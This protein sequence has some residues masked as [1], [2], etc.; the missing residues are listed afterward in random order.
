MKIFKLFLYVL[1]L[2]CY[3]YSLPLLAQRQ[4]GTHEHWLKQVEQNPK[5]LKARHQ[6]KEQIQQYIAHHADQQE[7]QVVTI[8]VVVHV[9][10][11]VTAENISDAQIQ[12]QIDVLNED[13]SK[14]NADISNIPTA[15]AG[16]AANSQIQFCL[17][18]QTPN[19]QATN[20]IERVQTTATGFTDNNAV[21]FLDLN[22]AGQNEGG[23]P[24]WDPTRYFNLWVCKLNSGLLGY[25]QFPDNPDL[26]TYGV[27]I[28][29][30]YFGRNG[31]AESPYDLGRTATHEVGHAL[32][33]YHIWGDDGGSCFGSDNINDTPNQ[34]DA[35][36]GC[37]NFP[38]T[39]F[40]TS[41]GAGI[42]FMNYMDYTDDAC[43][44]M[45]TNGQSQVMNATL[46][47]TFSSL[48]NSTACN[49]P[50]TAQFDAGISSIVN[51]NGEICAT[52]FAPIV[53]L[54]NYGSNTLTSCQI[55]YR[56]D[57][58]TTLQF[59]WTGSLTTNNTVDV[60]LPTI[61]TTAGSHNFTAFTQSPNGQT[62]NNAS[63]DSRTQAFTATSAV[64]VNIPLFEG[65]ENPS[66]PTGTQW[67]IDNPDSDIGWQRTTAAKKTGLASIVVNN[68]DYSAAGQTGSSIADDLYSPN[69]NLS[70]IAHAT[71]TF[72]VAYTT[73]TDPATG[74]NTWDSLQVWIVDAC[75]N[76]AARLYNKFS[77]TLSTASNTTDAFVPTSSQWRL[78]T[79][80]LTPYTSWGSV[81][82][83][84]RNISH[85]ENNLYLDDVNITGWA[86]GI[87]SPTEKQ[88]NLQIY[89]NPIAQEAVLTYYLPE[90][91]ST[92]ISIVDILGRTLQ[93]Y[94]IPYQ[95][96]GMHQFTI[97]D[98]ALP[99]K[100]MYVVQMQVGNEWIMRKIIKN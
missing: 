20:G 23:T 72:Q 16:V 9:V 12:S 41:S 70:S 8:P 73:Y 53:R 69:I 67:E 79:L 7:R 80:D 50:A 99:A 62:D 87:D 30:K 55:R 49:P 57:S 95:N 22:A 10:Y 93:T 66:F 56:I 100:G 82:L 48:I 1:L 47:N 63:N 21:K 24:A 64:G 84:F 2:A 27:V 91:Q 25:A 40:C 92:T 31:T 65:I 33:L 59:N 68:Y 88:A 5:L 6:H 44:Y 77:S 26:S 29:Y 45:F 75:G 85:Y 32:G 34:A 54:R 42:M 17:A 97:A 71:L 15:F 94:Q 28:N 90:G 98:A 96:S 19:G 14:T 18:Q 76:Q 89:P 4:C 81:Y 13:Y 11:R 83:V 39:D 43:M 36:G 78:E 60:T 52:S 37:P 46:N 58:G 35:T 86:V 38:M 61:S 3:S 74:G 51:P